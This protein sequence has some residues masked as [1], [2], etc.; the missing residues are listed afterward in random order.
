MH[1]Y[2][3]HHAVKIILNYNLLCS[4]YPYLKIKDVHIIYYL[5]TIA[6]YERSGTDIKDVVYSV[7]DLYSSYY[8]LQFTKI[9]NTE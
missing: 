5:L 4:F 7:I 9:K 3:T 6:N 1:I 8:V 2:L